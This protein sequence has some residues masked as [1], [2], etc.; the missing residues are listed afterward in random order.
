MQQFFARR[1]FLIV[2]VAVLALGFG[3]HPWLQEPAKLAPKNLIV[4]FVL[5]FMSLPLDARA[6]WLTL[7]HPWPALLATGVNMMVVPLL[8]WLV[9]PLLSPELG[10]GLMIVAAIP[11][12]LASAAVW[13]RRAGGND[14]IALMVTMITNLACFLV[15]P[16][17][18]RLMTKTEATLDFVQMMQQLLLFVV[19]PIL[20]AQ[21]CRIRLAV[22]NWATLHKVGLSILSQCGI[23]SIVL[24]GAID[25]GARLAGGH[26]TSISWLDWIVMLLA[27]N[28]VHASALGL[29]HLFGLL[30]QMERP[31]RIAVGFAGSQKTLAI[32]LA[33][34]TQYFGGLTIMPMIAYHVCQLLFDTLVIDYLRSREAKTAEKVAEQPV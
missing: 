29:G 17:W 22:A 30:C 13:T 7:R 26:D 31:D 25:G 2:L 20:I 32:G 14:A 1:W 8:A 3:G 28:V 4:A 11:C 10:I 6:M 27:V 24:F 16:A 34:G 19:L 23:L 12:T 21:L 9:S 15:T 33:I 18:L 5:F